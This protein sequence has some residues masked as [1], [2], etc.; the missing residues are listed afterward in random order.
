[1]FWGECGSCDMATVLGGHTEVQGL[2]SRLKE[3][4][5]RVGGFLFFI[6]FVDVVDVLFWF[7]FV[8]G[9]ERC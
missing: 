9:I 5:Y 3:N 6:C 7:R 8:A 1:V 4:T 2:P